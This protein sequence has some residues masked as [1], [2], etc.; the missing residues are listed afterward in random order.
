MEHLRDPNRSPSRD[1]ITIHPDLVPN[2]RHLHGEHTY[3]SMTIFS[4][5]TGL[6]PLLQKHLVSGLGLILG[7][8]ISAATV[9]SEYFGE[10]EMS[11]TFLL[12]VLQRDDTP[13][14]FL[15]LANVGVGHARACI[16]ASRTA[17]VCDGDGSCS[18]TLSFIRFIIL[19]RF[20]D[21]NCIG[22]SPGITGSIVTES[23]RTWLEHTNPNLR[24]HCSHLFAGGIGVKL[25][26]MSTVFSLPKNCMMRRKI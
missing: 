1:P 11:I 16:L 15:A 13:T 17:L 19:T 25:L 23:S 7:L 9:A 8:F 2:G 20:N 6:F 12:R 18:M 21:M 10:T 5:S 14:D 26:F 22:I 4:C 3:S 24:C